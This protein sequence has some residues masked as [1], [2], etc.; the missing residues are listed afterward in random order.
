MADLE[1]VY[2]AKRTAAGY[3]CEAPGGV[4]VVLPGRLKLTNASVL[5][6]PFNGSNQQRIH[7]DQAIPGFGILVGANTKA[8]I[9]QR[10][11]RGKAVRI[12]IGRFPTWKADDARKHARDLAV[13]MDKGIDPRVEERNA[14]AAAD[15][16]QKTLDLVWQDFR[17]KRKLKASTAS[18]YGRML[19]H[20]FEDWLKRPVTTIVRDDV[21]RRFSK[22]TTENGGPYANQAFRVLKA[23]LNFAAGFSG[24]DGQSL[25]PENPVKVLSLQKAWHRVGRRETLIPEVQLPAFLRAL[26]DL[27][28][29]DEPPSAEVGA[30]YIEFVIFTGVR[31]N[32]A[33]R[34]QWDA[35]DFEKKVVTIAETKNGKPHRLPLPDHL[36]S[37]LERRK[38]DAA[39]IKSEWVFPSAGHRIGEGHL[40]EPKFI[41]DAVKNRTGIKFC[42][43]DL[44]RTFATAAQRLKVDYLTLKRL[45]NHS[46]SGDVTA[47]YIPPDVEDLRE[48]MDRI[49]G[50][51]LTM[52]AKG[53]GLKLVGAS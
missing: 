14:K 25:M 37:L 49:A 28:H 22:I 2:F 18:Q 42:V 27:R 3:V 5:A 34:L 35:I 8:F 10:K 11:F 41:C 53:Q 46:T 47:G 6:L 23:I 44:R 1:F 12:T 45:L 26:D 13:Q 51:L 20:V 32:E 21:L 50:Y 7:W 40:S 19:N 24:P 31:R 48:S 16:D 17:A 36:V 9:I 15:A 30:D 52:K 43:H 39:R 29:A 33:A 4:E 38:V